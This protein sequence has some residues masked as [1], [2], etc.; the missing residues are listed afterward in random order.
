MLAAPRRFEE[1]VRSRGVRFAG[2]DDGPMRLMDRDT[3]QSTVVGDGWSA[4]STGLRCSP[5]WPVRR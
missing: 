5:P 1:F 2:I 4:S 3:D